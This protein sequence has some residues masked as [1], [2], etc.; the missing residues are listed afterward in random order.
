MKV[1][2]MTIDASGDRE[3]LITRIFDASSKLVYDAMT[4]PE[5]LKR[6]MFG[7]DDWELAICEIDLRP[8]GAFRYVWRNSEE[9][10]DMG[11]GGVFMELSEPTRIVHRELFDEDWTGGEATVTTLLTEKDGRTKLEMTIRYSSRDARDRV[12]K[13]GMAEGMEAGFARLDGLFAAA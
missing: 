5:L 4:R 2:Q 11:M 10:T 13:S 9:K 1:G 6:W 3:I 12:L 8:G 7:P